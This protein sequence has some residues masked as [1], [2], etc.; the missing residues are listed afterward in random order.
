MR[1]FAH[2]QRLHQIGVR[3]E[4]YANKPVV[5]IVNCWSD[6]STCHVHL[7]ERAQSVKHGVIAAG[8]FP[9]ELP[10]LSLGEVM[11]KPT[12][13]LYRNLLALEVEELIRS[14]P[15]DGVVLMGGCD[16]TTPGLVMGAVSAGLPCLFVPAGPTLNGSWRGKKIGT[17]THTRAY[18]DALR[19]GEISEADWADL[20]AVSVRSFGTCNTMGT[21]STMT[22]LTESLGLCLP[23][24]STIPAVDSAHARMALAAGE[25]M[26]AMIWDDLR[27]ADILTRQSFE[28]AIVTLFALGGSSNAVVH[29][30]AMAG[31]AGI[32]LTLDDIQRRVG[33]VPLIADLMPTGRFLMEDLHQAG[34]SLALFQRLSPLLDLTCRLVTGSSWKEALA[35]AQ[36]W[37]DEVIRPLDNPVTDRPALAVLRGNLAPNG[38]VIKPSAATPSLLVHR[39]KAVVFENAADLAARIDDPDLEVDADSV[40]VLRNAGPVG[41][42]MPEWGGL[43]IPQKLLRQGVRDMVRVSDARMSGTHFG[44]CVLHV[45]PEAAIGGPLALVQNGDVIALDA[46]KGLIELLVSDE[47]LAERLLAWRAPA[48][49]YPR[50]YG[51][52][53]AR[54]VLQADQGCDFDFL[55]GTDIIPEPDIY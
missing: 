20:E 10:A 35:G 42:A 46:T 28:N 22:M 38:A 43:P 3:R 17:G 26:V 8:G 31:R 19:A 9:V 53:F 41:A 44:T 55:T 14:H 23:G 39:G 25:R 33:T 6:L 5:G 21:A 27:P 24:A 32:A 54:H 15:L 7:R 13:M 49:T 30:L 37:N 47:V 45:A 12:T 50:G 52:L 51:A 48:P 36:S 16:K 1:A 29:L 4:D 40:L 11:V 34:G 2:R 18:W